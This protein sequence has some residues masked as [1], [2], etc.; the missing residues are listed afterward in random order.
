VAELN[1][2]LESIERKTR[3][4]IAR[5]AR[6]ESDNA[7][8]LDQNQKLTTEN[9]ALQTDLLLRDS[10]ISQLKIQGEV[11][12][13]LPKNGKANV[14]TQQIRKEIDQYITDVDSC[15]EWLQKS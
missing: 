11:T 1:E 6:L 7:A 12:Q 14:R 5:L 8:L 4:L 9:R 2:T 13:E 10:E 15:I 3:L